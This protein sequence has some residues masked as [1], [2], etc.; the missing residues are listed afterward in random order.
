M[1]TTTFTNPRGLLVG[2]LALGALLAAC[3]GGGGTTEPPVDNCP[4]PGLCTPMSTL[5]DTGEVLFLSCAGCHGLEGH[6]HPGS[7]PPLAN[8][9]Y[10]MAN[11]TK[12]IDIVLN[13]YN[14]SIFVNGM[15]YQSDMPEHSYYSDVEI[16]GILT[17]LRSTLND[18]TVV[19]CQEYDP[20]DSTT[21][22]PATGY[23]LC[24]KTPRDPA[25]RAIDSIA[26]WEVKRVRDTTE[27]RMN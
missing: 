1:K 11:R 2:A 15:W 12:T 21:F 17:Y 3:N 18:S 25:E 20:A 5:L 27:V 19:S 13:G 16:A 9:D 24:T 6:G 7:V 8:S 26:A 22:D 10:F 23:A 14:D 4:E